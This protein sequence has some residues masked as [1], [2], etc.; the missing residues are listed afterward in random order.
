M[1]SRAVLFLAPKPN[2]IRQFGQAAEANK[3]QARVQGEIES[4]Q[5]LQIFQ[6]QIRNGRALFDVIRQF[7]ERFAH[8]V[9]SF[10]IELLR[11]FEQKINPA[12]FH[13]NVDAARRSISHLK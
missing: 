4:E 8:A 13:Q 10:G 3:K 9:V 6:E 2:F 5:S 1:I 7:V 12:L 11:I